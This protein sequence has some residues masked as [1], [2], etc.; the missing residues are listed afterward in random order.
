M[1]A[2]P[3]EGPMKYESEFSTPKSS[4]DAWTRNVSSFAGDPDFSLTS[5]AD[6]N[7]AGECAD[8]AVT[9]GLRW[10]EWWL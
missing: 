3:L 8:A 7:P 2:R 10:L 5:A 4:G 1:N 9:D 6:D